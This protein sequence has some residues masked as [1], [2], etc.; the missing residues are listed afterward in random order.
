MMA[1]LALVGLCALLRSSVA[2]SPD[3]GQLGLTAVPTTVVSSTVVPTTVV[4][5]TTVVVPVPGGAPVVRVAGAAL[6][7]G[8]GAAVQLRGV[9]RPGLEFSCSQSSKFISD[10]YMGQSP[11]G[12]QLAYADT[13]ARSFLSW[14][15]AGRSGHAVNTVRLPLNE[16]CWLGIN[17][18][19]AAVSGA[20]YQAFVKRL[21]DDLTAQGMY[22]VLALHWAAPGSWLP[23][24][25]GAALANG[26]NLAP[27]ADHSIAFWQQVAS[28]YKGYSNVMFD[29]FTEPGIDCMTGSGCPLAAGDDY[30]A[31]D[32]WA[33]KLYRDG[34][35]YTYN[36]GDGSMYASRVGQTWQVAGTQQLVDAI[37]TAGATNPIAVETLGFGNGY[38]DLMGAYM[39]SDPA[40]QLVASIHAYD[41]SGYNPGEIAAQAVFDDM[42][43]KG[44]GPGPAYAYPVANITG[45]FPFYLGEFG[46]T[47]HCPGATNTAFTQNTMDWADAHG[48]SY[49][50]WGWDQGEGCWGPT[51]VTD[52]DNGAASA[53]GADVRQRLQARQ[54]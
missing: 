42:L 23:G 22:V 5:S 25:D 20:N 33:W 18:A 44:H 43:A 35:S 38:V 29:L 37:R 36:P 31:K 11:N 48:Y 45:R 34:G 3:P 52:N 4:P 30:F 53:Y 21:T 15:V 7:D 54:G 8:S 12:A 24:K 50:A 14:D 6:V 49:T 27:N 17:G 47:G 13:V 32:E 16:E 1:G 10:G 19:P 9:N 41:F 2:Q 40:G 28:T 51:L 46:T 39:P 26:Q